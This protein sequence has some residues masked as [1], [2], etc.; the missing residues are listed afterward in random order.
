ML[1]FEGFGSWGLIILRVFL[2]IIFIY[3]GMP[4]LSMPKAMAKGMGWSTGSVFLLGLVE[5]LSG[6]ALILGFY[7]EIA[8]LLVGIVM[9][10]ALFHKM[11]KWN[12]PFS[13]MDKMGWE[14]DLILLGAAIALLFIGAGLYSLDYMLG[15]FP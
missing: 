7:T 11:F 9:L 13:A 12:I 6:L 15:I 8:A 5:S 4:K 3:H 2:G 1:L 14:F 10:G